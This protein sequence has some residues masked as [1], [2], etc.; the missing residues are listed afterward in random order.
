MKKLKKLHNNMNINPL[1]L[2]IVIIVCL[3]SGIIIQHVCPSTFTFIV[4][5]GKSIIDNILSNCVIEI[6]IVLWKRKKG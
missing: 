3:V 1:I 5:M 6:V 4:T 2:V